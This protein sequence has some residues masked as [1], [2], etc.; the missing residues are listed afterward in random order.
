MTKAITAPVLATLTLNPALDLQTGVDIVEPETKLRCD[1]PRQ[2]AG[3]GGVN[4]ARV[5]GRLGGRA[6]CILPL[7]GP[8][9]QALQARLADEG[10]EARVVPITGETRQSFTVFDRSRGA[11]F[12]FVLPGPRLLAREIR[13]LE[14]ALE[15]LSP[16]PG[17]LVAS[18]SLPAGM[19][20]GRLARLASGFR[21]RGVR[22]A[23]DAS[24]EALRAGLEAGVWLVK[25]NLREL[26]ECLG[27]DLPDL[28]SQ[29]DAAR[30]LVRGGRAAW[31]A[32]SLGRDGALLVGASFAAHAPAL[33]IT[34]VST[35]GAGDSFL[36]GLVWE[37]SRG[38]SPREALA[39]AVAAASATLMSPGSGMARS[40]D[41]RR[42]R[43]EVRIEVLEGG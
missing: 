28:S 42:L 40:A 17:V 18:G 9:G 41:I 25:P 6:T 22:L 31:V 37:L 43:P 3:G 39:T 23:L 32:L 29:L 12:R 10:L 8:A 11:E 14:T 36:A 30:E 24:G 33:P 34:P 26:R 16:R 4:V 13:A 19:D 15:E 21:R 5:L 7:G 2:D 38:R 27:R 1:V 20:P 35:V